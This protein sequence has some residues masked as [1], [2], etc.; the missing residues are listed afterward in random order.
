MSAGRGKF[1]GK[2]F[3]FAVPAVRDSLRF[4]R[5]TWCSPRSCVGLTAGETPTWARTARVFGRERDAEPLPFFPA[6]RGAGWS[7]EN[8]PCTRLLR[9]VKS[10]SYLFMSVCV[11]TAHPCV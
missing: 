2:E 11:V 8:D 9:Y 10:C 3:L 7:V 5:G 4:G 1:S 6:G